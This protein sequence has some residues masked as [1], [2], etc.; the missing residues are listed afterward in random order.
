MNV[1]LNTVLFIIGSIACTA[2][3]WRGQHLLG[4]SAGITFGVLM[5]TV[6]FVVHREFTTSRRQTFGR[7]LIVCVFAATVFLLLWFSPNVSPAV[8]ILSDRYQ[9]QKRVEAQVQN[10]LAQ[11]PRFARLRSTS[12][13]KK[14]VFLTIHG[15]VETVA[16]LEALRTQMKAK[17]PDVDNASLY[18]RVSVN[19]SNRLFEG[20]D[21]DI[22]EK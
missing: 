3:F 10:V 2:A 19:D 18:W 9:T 20:R 17:C 7:R 15:S 8:A 21:S 16:D 12:E 14:A 6:M 4:T 13:V 5:A 22:F 1:K 11:E